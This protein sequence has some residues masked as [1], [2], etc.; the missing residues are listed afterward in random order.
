MKTK[1]KKITES[2][3]SFWND[4]S[5]NGQNNDIIQRSCMGELKWIKEK[6]QEKSTQNIKVV[7]LLR[8]LGLVT[9]RVRMG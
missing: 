2:H 8:R 3:W 5:G 6:L 7:M 1:S 9:V 4:C